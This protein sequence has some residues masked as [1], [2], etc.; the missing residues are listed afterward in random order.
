MFDA[1]MSRVCC[2]V[3]KAK[4]KNF[5]EISQKFFQSWRYLDFRVFAV[6]TVIQ[7][8]HRICDAPAEHQRL[9]AVY[10]L[11]PSVDNMKFCKNPQAPRK[12]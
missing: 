10:Q 12:F 8:A 5:A 1:W 11:Y 4:L 2:L 7:N 9:R 6:T 3:V